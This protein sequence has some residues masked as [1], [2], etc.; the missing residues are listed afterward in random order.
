MLYHW[1]TG[2]A[3]FQVIVFI[4][5]LFIIIKNNILFRIIYFFAYF[6]YGEKH[7]FCNTFFPSDLII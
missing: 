7:Q 5:L 4:I 2:T 6:L 1:V 3:Y